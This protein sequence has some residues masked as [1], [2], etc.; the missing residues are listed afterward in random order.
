MEMAKALTAGRRYR[1][2]YT[3]RDK[4]GHLTQTETGY[5]PFVQLR[6]PNAEDA[7]VAANHVTG[8]PV[9]DVV[10]LEHAS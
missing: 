10:R 5:L 2:Y 7:Q 8:C 9:A 3:P 6:A 4:L 1:C